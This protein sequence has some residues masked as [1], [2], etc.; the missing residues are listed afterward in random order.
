MH[1]PNNVTD[2]AAS[3]RLTISYKQWKMY[4]P[5]MVYVLVACEINTAQK[6]RAKLNASSA[7]MNRKLCQI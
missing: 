4:G 7:I 1:G 6:K 5:E 3:I 2:I